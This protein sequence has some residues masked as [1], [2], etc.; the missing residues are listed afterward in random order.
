MASKR[1]VTNT[2][3]QVLETGRD[4]A[5]SSVK[6]VKETFSPWEMIRNSF[7]IKESSNDTQ[8]PQ[9]KL[10][11]MRGKGDKHTPLDFDKLNSTYADQ[12]KQKIE[13]MKQ[14]LFQLV[15]RD[16]EKSV[17]R[18]HQKKAETER[19]LSQEEADKQR[20]EQEKRRNSGS[21]A[22]QGKMKGMRRK[23]AAEP[24]PAETKPGSSKQ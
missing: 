11:E 6:Q 2:F 7:D 5:K 9:S 22:P 18:V 8:D 21:A 24:Q 17:Q 14:R 12:D 3:E 16:D 20:R 15:K 1:I 4:M 23:K 10:K 19:V 13:I